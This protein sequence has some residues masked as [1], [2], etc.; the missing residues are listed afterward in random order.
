MERYGFLYARYVDDIRIGGPRQLDVARDMAHFNGIIE[1][2]G[3]AINPDKTRCHASE[4][5]FC[6]PALG[7]CPGPVNIEDYV[8]SDEDM[9]GFGTEL[10][11]P[12][13]TNMRRLSHEH[14]ETSSPNEPF[15]SVR[16]FED[17][18][19]PQLPL[20]S[21]AVERYAVRRLV[22]RGHPLF[23][24][25]QYELAVSRLGSEGLYSKAVDSATAL[26]VGIEAMAGE[27]G[28]DPAH[29]HRAVKFLAAAAQDQ[30]TAVRAIT[31]LCSLYDADIPPHIELEFCAEAKAHRHRY[32]ATLP[33]LRKG[34]E[35]PWPD[36]SVARIGATMQ[37]GKEDRNR[38]L[39]VAKD[40]HP[41]GKVA[42]RLV[43][44]AAL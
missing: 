10:D 20:K 42:C 7:G 21:A 35:D 37:L 23:K 30:N 36:V 4:R 15:D 2:A 28:R 39:C 24:G 26:A 34:I 22:S 19:D 5:A 11:S 9:A 38:F 14:R 13:P 27:R 3:F 32:A 41:A 16:L 31:N 18:V 8:L 12:Y 29:Q 33:I 17:H 6:L 40:V 44:A 43:K 1:E 25:S